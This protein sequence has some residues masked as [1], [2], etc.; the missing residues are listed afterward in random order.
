MKAESKMK[1]EFF[2]TVRDFKQSPYFSDDLA[3]LVANSKL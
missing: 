2:F 3:E 1:K